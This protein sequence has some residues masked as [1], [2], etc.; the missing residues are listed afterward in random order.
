MNSDVGSARDAAEKIAVAAIARAA[1]KPRYVIA[2]AGPPGAGKSTVS[3]ALEQALQVRGETASIV[4]MDG[5][6]FDNAILDEKGWR[7]RKG[8]P[9]TF[10]VA[11]YGALLERLIA[12]PGAD[13]AVPVFD[14]AADLSRGSARIVKGGTR[15]V[16]AEGNYLLLPEAPWKNLRPLFD[17]S[18]FLSAPLS[19]IE[20]RILARWRSYGFSADIAAQRAEGND[21]PNARLVLE[22]SV[23]ADMTVPTA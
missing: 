10:D 5:F 1:T 17:F 12:N 9:H 15:F 20:G 16:I 11:G 18:V 22:R 3:D 13:I 14:R 8:A 2:V 7:S 6:H 23:G 21:L 4:P 19:T